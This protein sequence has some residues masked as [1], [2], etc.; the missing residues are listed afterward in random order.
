VQSDHALGHLLP[1]LVPL[2]LAEGEA[3]GSGLLGLVQ[4]HIGAAQVFGLERR[5]RRRRRKMG[6][7]PSGN[8]VV[9]VGILKELKENQ[10]LE[11]GDGTAERW[12]L[13]R[14]WKWADRRV[15]QIRT[16]LVYPSSN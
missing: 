12:N 10:P 3:E 16:S 6:L 14:K 1:V 9:H 2:L 11:T 15:E 5:R 8:S 4:V 13:V 7:I